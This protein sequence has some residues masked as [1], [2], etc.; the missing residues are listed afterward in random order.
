MWVLL[1]CA[2]CEDVAIGE[3]RF[4]DAERGAGAFSQVALMADG[5]ALWAKLVVRV[6]LGGTTAGGT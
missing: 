6:R 3:R 5:G 2:R 1:T 4:V